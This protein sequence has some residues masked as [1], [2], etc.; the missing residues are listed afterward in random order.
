MKLAQRHRIAQVILHKHGRVIVQFKDGTQ[1]SYGVKK[2][3]QEYP[4]GLFVMIEDYIVP[5]ETK[6]AASFIKG[7]A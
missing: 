6:L 5:R 2:P 4:P 3:I 1:G 7:S